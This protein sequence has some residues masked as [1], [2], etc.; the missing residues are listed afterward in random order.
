MDGPQDQKKG[1]AV[2]RT[3][4]ILAVVVLMAGCG[5][6]EK[7]KDRKLDDLG[8]LSLE[9]LWDKAR[10]K[11][12]MKDDEGWAKGPQQ[13]P[14]DG[15]P[16]EWVFPFKT[17][18]IDMTRPN[19]K[20]ERIVLGIDFTN[21]D[22]KLYFMPGGR[23]G[24]RMRVKGGTN[25]NLHVGNYILKPIPKHEAQWEVKVVDGHLD[26]SVDGVPLRNKKYL[27]CPVPGAKLKGLYW[28]PDAGRPAGCEVKFGELKK[29]SAE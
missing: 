7:F 22:G 28:S 27:P 10:G 25:Y 5:T 9:A 26:I 11:P 4:A 20:P 15:K 21:G 14:V 2:M 18:N 3:A 17:R 23:D 19:D 12:V 24:V 16:A 1:G 6:I 13:I 8:D 29:G